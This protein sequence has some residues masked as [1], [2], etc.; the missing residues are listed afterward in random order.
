MKQ[1]YLGQKSLNTIGLTFALCCRFSKNC[2]MEGIVNT[3]SGER[4]MI[5]SPLKNMS[6][7]KKKTNFVGIS[8][9]KELTNVTTPSNR[10]FRVSVEGNIGAGKSTLIKYFSNFKEI[11]TYPEPIE[12]WRNVHGH[13][14]L[15]LLYTDINKWYNTFQMYVQLTRLKVQTTK[16]SSPMTTVQMFERS[17]Q[18]NRYCFV[19]QAYNNSLLHDA[20]YAIIDQ[21]YRWIRENVDINLDLIVYLRST[22]EIVYERMKVRGRPEEKGITLEYLTQLHDS[23]EKWLM[24]DDERFNTIP[25]LVLDADK[26]LEDILKEYKRNEGKIMGHDKKKRPLIDA[27]NKEKAKRVLVV[28]KMN[29]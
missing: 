3:I 29:L 2:A 22:P 21:W 5:V 27:A 23:H 18:N 28:D 14:L 12:W 11:E 15:D 16:Q 25:V 8:P 24:T 13:N 1:L 6:P 20:N 19:E 7:P 9:L 4:K 26:A 10:P 17:V